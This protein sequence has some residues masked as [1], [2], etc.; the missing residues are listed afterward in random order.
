[1]AENRPPQPS[2]NDGRACLSGGCW[3]SAGRAAVD[4]EASNRTIAASQVVFSQD[5]VQGTV[6][7]LPETGAAFAPTSRPTLQRSRF[8]VS[9]FTLAMRWP[10]ISSTV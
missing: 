3:D 7:F 6:L 4:S 8:S 5:R 10:S 9:I 1:M 2:S